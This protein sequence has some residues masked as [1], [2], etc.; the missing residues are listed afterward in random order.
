MWQWI[1]E[2][3]ATIIIS[4]ILFAALAT[5]AVKL[6]K[7]KK[8]GKSSCGAGCKNCA[9]C[10]KCHGGCASPEEQQRMTEEAKQRLAA[11]EAARKAVKDAAASADFAAKTAQKSA[12]EQAD[13]SQEKSAD[14]SAEK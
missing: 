1:R 5:I 12:E 9:L 11:K 4:V 10:G 7:D 13:L 2:N 14:H 6:I 8:Q 3:P